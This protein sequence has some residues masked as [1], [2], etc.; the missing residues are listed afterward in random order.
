MGDLP[1]EMETDQICH[2]ATGDDAPTLVPLVLLNK[3]L[4]T[5][6]CAVPNYA[7]RELFNSNSP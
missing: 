1:T 4:D 2:H 5:S 3:H 6:R 7:V